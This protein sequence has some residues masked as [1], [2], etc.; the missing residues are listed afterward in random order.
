MTYDLKYPR[1]LPLTLDKH[2][3]L[4]LRDGSFHESDQ[5]LAI[6]AMKEVANE[7]YNID[8]TKDGPGSFKLLGSDENRESAMKFAL[9]FGQKKMPSF[10]NDLIRVGDLV[11]WDECT[12][13][14]NTELMIQVV[15]RFVDRGGDLVRPVDRL[16]AESMRRDMTEQ[17][18]TMGL[19]DPELVPDGLVAEANGGHD[20]VRTIRDIFGGNGGDM[21]SKMRK[22]GSPG[23][24]G[25]KMLGPFKVGDLSKPGAITDILKKALGE[26]GLMDDEEE[27]DKKGK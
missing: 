21:M 22:R 18:N 13:N 26:M 3:I 5:H 25:F 27:D 19:L 2:I 4:D 8:G 7:V 23:D 17:R 1:L 6:L 14:K 16:V 15:E 9:L 12:H 10:E 11:T 20:P 24:I